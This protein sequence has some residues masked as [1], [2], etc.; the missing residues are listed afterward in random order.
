MESWAMKELQIWNKSFFFFSLLK[1]NGGKRMKIFVSIFLYSKIYDCSVSEWPCFCEI[2]RG[3]KIILKY[4]VGF[5]S[6]FLALFHCRGSLSLL[7]R[8]LIS[9]RTPAVAVQGSEHAAYTSKSLFW[10]LLQLARH[11]PLKQKKQGYAG[12]VQFSKCLMGIVL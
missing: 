10:S 8:D 7:E 11:R 5:G 1:Q 12:W 4:S 6:V 9:V 2:Q 3:K